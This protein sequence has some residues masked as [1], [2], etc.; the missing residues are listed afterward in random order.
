ML[1]ASG[2][3]VVVGQQTVIGPIAAPGSSMST[4]ALGRR[5]DMARRLATLVMPL[6]LLLGALVPPAAGADTSLPLPASMAAVGDSITQAASSNGT[7][8]ADAPQ[9]SWST[10][11][12]T[13]VNSHYQ[14]LLA[15]GAPIS[16]QNVNRS[17]SGAKVGDL[18][19]QMAGV[20]TLHPDYLTVLIGGNDLCTDTVAQMTSV[21]DFGARFQAAMET[22]TTGSPT[23]HVYVVSIPDVY[24]LWNLFHT[25]WV[26]RFVWS[27]GD[28]CQSLLANPTS[29]QAADVQRRADV[30]Q[31]N[32]AYNAQLADVCGS[33]PQ[34][35]FDGNAVFNTQFSKSDISGD[36][37]HP[38]IAGQAKLASVTW[39]AGYAWSVTPPPNQA[40][41]ASFTSSCSGLTCAFTDTST[42]PDGTIASR[43]WNF[44]DGATSTAASPSHTYASGG[45]FTVTLVVTDNDGATGTAQSTVTVA[46]AE[47]MWVGALGS[48]ASASKGSW[49]AT[50]TIGVVD[51]SGPV[52]GV[53]VTGSWSTG[54]GG[55]SC[56]TNS[57][58]SCSLSSSS[59]GK[60][61]SSVTFTVGNLAKADWTYVPSSN[62]ATSIVVSK[63]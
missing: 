3:A 6:V 12:N 54:S 53:V 31:R 9:N 44:G 28:I 14:R 25:S 45:S 33:F 51:A 52:G 35:R 60:K 13:T 63:P 37:F 32:I 61:T 2:I 47:P 38:S 7:L 40:P 1:A 17:V 18:N 57:Q 20:V 48:S 49:V 10:G 21:A 59:L 8:G 41:T 29:T 23:T 42:D 56:T 62:K 36:Y 26:A 30:R 39:A 46:T 11:T 43:S 19:A 27:V 50:V 5:S 58:G 15:L 24:Q 55:T 16:G 4:A 22:L 34:C